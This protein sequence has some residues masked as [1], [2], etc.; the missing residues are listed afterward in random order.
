M[1]DRVEKTD[2]QWRKELTPEQ[3]HVTRG[4]GTEAAFT[5]LYWN[6]KDPGIYR[7][8]CCAVELFHSDTK[9]DS[10]T[11]WPSFTAPVASERV[12]TETDSS[13]GMVRIEVLCAACDAHLGHLFDDGPEP[14][15]Q[16][17]CLNSAALKLDRDE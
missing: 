16:R 10:G 5:G 6:C 12:R 14:T 4:K 1:S 7:C 15:G 17:Y 2:E 11:G 9:Y 13:H 3:H 8:V